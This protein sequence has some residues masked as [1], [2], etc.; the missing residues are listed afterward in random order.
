M[1]NMESG[2]EKMNDNIWHDVYFNVLIDIYSIIICSDKFYLDGNE[3]FMNKL[4]EN[5]QTNELYL[6]LENN[7]LSLGADLYYLIDIFPNDINLIQQVKEYSFQE[8]LNEIDE[9]NI[10][11]MENYHLDDNIPPFIFEDDHN[12]I[13]EV[14]AITFDDGLWGIEHRYSSI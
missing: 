12:H 4:I 3:L 2:L 6:L 14:L 10:L 8:M 11:F 1:D 9:M 13:D 7:I 5:T